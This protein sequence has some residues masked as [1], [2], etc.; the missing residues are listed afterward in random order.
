[1]YENIEWNPG[2]PNLFLPTE[3]RAAAC[4]QHEFFEFPQT[5]RVRGLHAV[6][7]RGHWPFNF[8]VIQ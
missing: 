8:S 3:Q 5:V 1:M 7:Q 6:V 2:E 4:I